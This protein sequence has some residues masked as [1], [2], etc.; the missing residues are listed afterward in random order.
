[1]KLDFE[2]D[3][4]SDEIDLALGPGV[5][6]IVHN[7]MI[8]CFLGLSGPINLHHKQPSPPL[9][10]RRWANL[11]RVSFGL[12]T[13]SR[14]TITHPPTLGLIVTLTEEIFELDIF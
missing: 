9:C 4:P 11:I 10:A 14:Q 13:A 8:L 3:L 1:M 6:K 12:L 7:F 2:L 5:V